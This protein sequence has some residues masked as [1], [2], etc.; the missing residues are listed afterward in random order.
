MSAK[1]GCS[2]GGHGSLCS[3]NDR[4]G[5]H[6][7]CRPGRPHIL[8]S[9]HDFSSFSQLSKC[10]YGQT[11]EIHSQKRQRTK[12]CFHH[13]SILREAMPWRFLFCSVIARCFIR[14]GMLVYKGTRPLGNANSS[15]IPVADRHQM[16]VFQSVIRAALRRILDIFIILI[17]SC[18]FLFQVSLCL[19]PPWLPLILFKMWFRCWFNLK[20]HNWR[21]A[22]SV[23]TLPW[24][25]TCETRCQIKADTFGSTLQNNHCSQAWCF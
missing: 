22:T 24:T 11:G 1:V 5:C 20:C 16:K 17:L 13:L 9:D 18:C 15:A 6:H 25:L 19:P 8:T 21:R 4:L 23:G 7:H 12:F 14:L 3:V 2:L 10:F